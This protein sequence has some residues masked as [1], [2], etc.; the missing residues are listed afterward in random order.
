MALLAVVI[1]AGILACLALLVV[2]VKVR[3]RVRAMAGAEGGWSAA[4][5]GAVGPIAFTAGASPGGTK[6]AAHLLGRRLLG[7]TRVPAAAKSAAKRVPLS[8][9]KALDTAS[10]LLRRV[11]VDRCDAVV[12]G[13][14]DDPATSARVLGLVSAASAVLAPRATVSSRV[15]WLADS[16]FVDVDCDL[17]ASFVP[18][19]LGWDLA[20]GAWMRRSP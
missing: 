10:A 18:L 7:G 5:G 12:H 15:D 2:R 13:A 4:A 1:A 19:L 14:A 11:R 20:R 3:A 17:E 8:P 16:P 6:W 9:E